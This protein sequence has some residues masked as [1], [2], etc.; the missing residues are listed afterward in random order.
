MSHD[1][2]GF[3]W[4]SSVQYGN[5]ELVYDM[6]SHLRAERLHASPYELMAFVGVSDWSLGRLRKHAPIMTVLHADLISTLDQDEVDDDCNAAQVAK[7]V[8]DILTLHN[9]QSRD[10]WTAIPK[11]FYHVLAFR[12]AKTLD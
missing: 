6:L 11:V 7:T 12:N 3:R 9:E 2:V 4:G 5:A 8:D 1:D 10:L